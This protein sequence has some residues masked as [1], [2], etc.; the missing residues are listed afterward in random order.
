MVTFRFLTTRCLLFL[1]GIS[2]I[3][4]AQYLM[5][6]KDPVVTSFVFTEKLERLLHTS[7]HLLA[8]PNMDNII[9][10]F[11]LLVIGMGCLWKILTFKNKLKNEFLQ[12][13]AAYVSFRPFAYTFGAFTIITLFTFFIFIKNINDLAK[14]NTLLI[15]WIPALV[16]LLILGFKWDKK[17]KITLKPETRFFDVMMM[18]LIFICSLIIGSYKLNIIPNSMFHDEYPFL[19]QALNIIYNKKRASFFNVGPYQ[20]GLPSIYYQAVVMKLLGTTFWSWRF[21]SVLAAG[22]AVFPTYLIAHEFFERRVAFLSALVMVVTPYFIAFERF[23]YN[24]SQSIF[25]VALGIYLFYRALKLNSLFYFILSGIVTGLGFY[26]YWA[27]CV[28]LIVNSL[29]IFSIIFFKFIQTKILPSKKY[30][31]IKNSGRS[32]LWI[33]GM[34]VFIVAVGVTVLP[35]LVSNN[36]LVANNRFIRLLFCN[37]VY[38]GKFFPLPELYRSHLPIEIN[39]VVFFYRLDLYFTLLM[40]GFFR[41]ILLFQNPL[42][43]SNYFL[44]A[45]LAGSFSAVFYFIGLMI[46]LKQIRYPQFLLLSIWFFVGGIAIS[47]FATDPPRSAHMISV[48]PV[49]AILIAIGLTTCVDTLGKLMGLTSQLILNGFLILLVTSIIIVDLRDYFIKIPKIFAPDAV[50]LVHFYSISLQKPEMIIYI[51]E[52]PAPFYFVKQTKV[53]NLITKSKIQLINIKDILTNQ[54]PI[55]AHASYTFF[56]SENI[57]DTVVPYLNRMFYIKASPH[58][59]NTKFSNTLLYSVIAK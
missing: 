44:I 11:G 23:G 53:L 3:G 18:S 38:A 57:S 39:E 49:I 56:F 6:Q 24:N 45:P 8:I 17:A 47:S 50:S 10:A 7:V 1:L 5:L 14:S 33:M 37:S 12:S 48:L 15:V 52:T 2:C 21:S 4:F 43:N 16:I 9:V 13:T 34:A 41:T 59:Y 27:S 40:I 36:I 30:Y 35:M 55:H 51:T 22:L 20:F 58:L 31:L 29:F 26:T 54:Y 25:F 19:E 46:M 28:G 32:H 42:M